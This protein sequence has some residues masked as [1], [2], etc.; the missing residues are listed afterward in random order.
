MVFMA[1]C[2][3]LPES[4]YFIQGSALFSPIL[5]VSFLFGQRVLMAFA[6]SS[7]SQMQRFFQRPCEKVG[8]KYLLIILG[9]PKA[10][11]LASVN[12]G[13]NPRVGI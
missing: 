8:K 12:L 1:V 7:H 2:C 13:E 9:L 4:L 11:K 3:R 5:L 10:G 6:F